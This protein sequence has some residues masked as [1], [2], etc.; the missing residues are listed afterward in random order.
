[1]QC[2]CDVC[3]VSYSRIETLRIH[4]EKNH[5]SISSRMKK[6]TERE[7]QGNLTIV[8]EKCNLTNRISLPDLVLVHDKL[9]RGN[10]VSIVRGEYYSF[11]AV[12]YWLLSRYIPK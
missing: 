3:G 8:P 5:R 11:K 4:V 9:P 10:V 2:I 6:D 7:K 12:I 1:M